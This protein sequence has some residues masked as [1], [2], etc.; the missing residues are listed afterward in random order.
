MLIGLDSADDMLQASI[1]LFFLAEG[2]FTRPLFV[3]LGKSAKGWKVTARNLS[4]SFK[5][6]KKSRPAKK[7]R[8][9]TKDKKKKKRRGKKSRGQKKK[10]RS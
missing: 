3:N 8:T 2:V 6:L 10:K 7:R 9:S 1:R 5:Q 4:A